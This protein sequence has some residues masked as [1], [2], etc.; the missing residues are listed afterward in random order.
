VRNQVH[1]SNNSAATSAAERPGFEIPPAGGIAGVSRRWNAGLSDCR[2]DPAIRNKYRNIALLGIIRN[3]GIQID[4]LWRRRRS[5]YQ[6]HP[7]LP[8]STVEKGCSGF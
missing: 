2:Q 6:C 4:N 5:G 8:S 1:R 3:Q 7:H